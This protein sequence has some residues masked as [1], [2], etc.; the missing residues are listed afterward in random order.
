[1]VKSNHERTN[2]PIDTSAEETA[3]DLMRR[4]RDEGFDSDSEMLA[5]ALGRPASQVKGMFDGEEPIDK[6][7]VMK[8]RAIAAQRQIDLTS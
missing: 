3:R 7:L 6:D 1:M 8:L 4:V 5:L 2:S